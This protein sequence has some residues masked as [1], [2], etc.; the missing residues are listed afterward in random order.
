MNI[1]IHQIQEPL[2]EFG[3]G[4]TGVDPKVMLTQV[5]PFAIHKSS[6][7]TEIVCGIVGLPHEIEQVRIWIARMHTH[8]VC[9]ENNAQR[10]RELPG[11]EAAYHSTI[12]IEDRFV[13]ALDPDKYERLAAESGATAFTALLDF[14]SEAITAFFGDE[15]P[16]CIL[17]AFPPKVAELRISN[18]RLTLAE[19][20]ILER[21]ENENEANQLVLFKPTDEERCLGSA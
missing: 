4:A 13:S 18:T 8:L 10:Y 1:E 20:T 6:P 7:P 11:M 21:L 12:R 3:N 2:L 15:R 17:V 14:Y 9:N 5:G 16:D 19:R